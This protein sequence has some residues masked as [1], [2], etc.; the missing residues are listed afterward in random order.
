MPMRW[1]SGGMK[2][3]PASSVLCVLAWVMSRP[4]SVILPAFGMRSPT[5]ASTSSFC[6]LPSTPA[7]PTISPARTSSVKLSTAVW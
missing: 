4:A 6:P 2:P 3:S 7:M 1:R 5:I